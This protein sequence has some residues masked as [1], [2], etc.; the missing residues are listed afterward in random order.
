MANK[1]QD[2]YA[3]I[4]AQNKARTF[5]YF[6][7]RKDVEK[8]K[9]LDKISDPTTLGFK[10]YFDF[11]SDTGL[12]A[13]E[14]NVNSALAYLKRTKQLARY[15]A[16]LHFIDVL[17]E[18]NTDFPYLFQ[19]LDGLDTLKI[20]LGFRYGEDSKIT[21]NMLETVDMKVQSLISAYRAIV[22]DDERWVETLPVNLR[23]F[24][25]SIYLYSSMVYDL[26]SDDDVTRSAIPNVMDSTGYVGSPDNFNHMMWQLNECEISVQDSG[27]SVFES[28]SSN[29]ETDFAKNN[30]SISYRFAKPS[31]LFRTIF[32]NMNISSEE[33]NAVQKSLITSATND[34]IAAKLLNAV[35]KPIQESQVIKELNDKYGSSEKLKIYGSGLLNDATNYGIDYVSTKVINKVNKLFYGNVYGFS[36]STLLENIANGSTQSLIN[37]AGMF[38]NKSA[39]LSINGYAKSRKNIYTDL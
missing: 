39:S 20:K 8:F 3:S 11:V 29:T 18:L 14:Q 13:Q 7:A 35:V 36:A 38:T 2:N 9:S 15:E 12:L 17:K 6:H 34:S 32:S 25:C 22:W 28:A 19:S 10:V 21:F 33:L 30:I 24:S 16:L 1:T 26:Y 37:S 23:R 31:G 27:N 5:A 4:A